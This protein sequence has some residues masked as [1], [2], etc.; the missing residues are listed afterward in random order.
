MGSD[1]SAEQDYTGERFTVD[2]KGEIRVEHLHRYLWASRLRTEGSWVDAASGAGYG[3]YLLSGRGRTVVGFDIDR[4]TVENARRVFHADGLDFAVASVYSLD[5]EASSVDVM[6]S[7]ETIEHV[8][9]PDKALDE[10]NRCL[11]TEGILAV[12]SPNKATYSS[13]RPPH[14]SF[15]RFEYYREEFLGELQGRFE[16]VA[17]LG[18]WTLGSVSMIAPLEPSQSWMQNAFWLNGA[19]EG[20]TL[21][22]LFEPRYLIAVASRSP[23]N[24]DLSPSIAIDTYAVEEV[25]EENARLR[26]ELNDSLSLVNREREKALQDIEAVKRDVNDLLRLNGHLEEKYALAKRELSRFVQDR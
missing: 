7:F 5:R 19:T 18:Q 26:R 9:Q 2:Q 17:L 25:L 3:S 23:I 6:V 4:L 10:F 21:D 22:S 15:H 12:S 14:N 8:D 20:V 1:L 13:N 24:L 16:H 11:K